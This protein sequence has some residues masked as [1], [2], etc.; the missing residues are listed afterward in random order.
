ME[1]SRKPLNVLARQLNA[2]IAIRLKN[3]LEYR[4]TMVHCDNFM[5]IILNGATEYYN[6]GQLLANYGQV[7]VRG[8]NVLYIMLDASRKK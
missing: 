7:L 3:G 5:N 2:Y 4:G 6:N 8:N 1:P